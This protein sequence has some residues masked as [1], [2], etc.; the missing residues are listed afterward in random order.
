MEPVSIEKWLCDLSISELVE[1]KALIKDN[2]ATG[3]IAQ[4][5]KQYVELYPKYVALEDRGA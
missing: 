5:V 2:I 3:N 4:Y 1:M